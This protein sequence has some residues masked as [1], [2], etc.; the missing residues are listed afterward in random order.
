MMQHLHS[1]NRHTQNPTGCLITGT[2][3]KAFSSSS[4]SLLSLLL[5]NTTGDSSQCIMAR[6]NCKDKNQKELHR[7]AIMDRY[8]CVIK[9]IQ[10]N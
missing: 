6:K 9:E 4:R 10:K 2:T 5:L 3:L 8:Y 1:D 7:N